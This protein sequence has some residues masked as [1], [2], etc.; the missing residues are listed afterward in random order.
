MRR[1]LV[2]TIVAAMCLIAAPAAF[3]TTE[4][5]QAG[6]V[7]A[8]FTFQGKF[9][10]YTGQTLEIAQGGTVFYDEPVVSNFCGELCAPGITGKSAVEVV[11]VEHTGQPDVVLDLYSGG[12]HCCTIVQI[13]SFDPGTM[14]YVKTERNFG[15]PGVRISDLRH[16]GR[17]EF[18]TADDSFAYEFTD[19]AGSALPLE[20]LSFSNRHFTNVTD[21]YP[22]LVAK[23]AALYLKFFKEDASTHYQDSVGLA[24]A[25]AADEERLGHGSLVKTFLAQQASQGHLNSALY[26]QQSGQRFVAKLL[27]FLRTHGYI[28]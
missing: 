9:P 2:I 24:A 3:A 5:A 23:E 14:T 11:D 20:I 28:R 10:D 22:R 1:V 25:W 6:N 26:P 7:T 27:R 18:V 19:Y 12:A 13:F 8:T 16:N 4:T 21:S 17:F 15:D